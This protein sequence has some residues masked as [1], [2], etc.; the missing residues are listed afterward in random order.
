[1]TT[2]KDLQH[3]TVNPFQ[4]NT[5]AISYRIDETLEQGVH[6][7]DLITNGTY[8]LGLWLDNTYVG[9]FCGNS[10]TFELAND[11]YVED[12]IIKEYNE[13]GSIES[14]FIGIRHTAPVGTY[15]AQSYESFSLPNPI[16][17]VTMYWDDVSTFESGDDTGSTLE[18]DSPWGTQ[19]STDYVYNVLN[20]YEYVPIKVNGAYIDPAIE[21][22]DIVSIDG[23]DVLV[24]NV[25][26]LFDGITTA[27]IEVPINNE[28]NYDDPYN[29]L[30]QNQFK[31]KIS[32]GDAYQ[33]V[34]ISRDKGIE[35]LVSPDGT[36]ENATG[37]YY[38][39]LY[40]G[41]AFQTRDNKNQEWHDW[42]YFDLDEN[43]FKLSLYETKKITDGKFTSLTN[44]YNNLVMKVDGLSSEI[45]QIQG[46]NIISNFIGELGLF[47]WEF[48]A[49]PLYPRNDLYPNNKLHP[50]DRN[51]AIMRVVETDTAAGTGF[52]LFAVGK[53]ISQYAIVEGGSDYSLYTRTKGANG[54]RFILREYSSA[55][56][57]GS[58]QETVLENAISSS[59]WTTLNHTLTIKEH[60]QS[61][62][63]VVEK[64]NYNETT[65]T[66]S[67]FNFGN[68]RPYTQSI[69]DVN[70]KAEY[71]KA[72]SE[73]T[74]EGFAQ[75]VQ[76][77]ETLD[78]RVAS[79]ES[80]LTQNANE[81]ATKVSKNKVISEIN[82]SA[83]TVGIK[84]NKVELEG[85]TSINKHFKVLP[86]G[87]VEF[88]NATGNNMTITGNLT[89]G[90]IAGLNFN[91]NNITFPNGK[92]LLNSQ[93][94]AIQFKGSAGDNYLGVLEGAGL[95]GVGGMS[96][97]MDGGQTLG[98]YSGQY[99]TS[100]MNL[101]EIDNASNYGAPFSIDSHKIDLNGDVTIGRNLL[102]SGSSG[103]IT[104]WGNIGSSSNR[105]RRIYLQNQ[106]NVSSD[107]KFKK[108][109]ETISDDLIDVVKDIKPKQYHTVY[110]DK[111]HF[112]YIA[113]DV[114]KALYNHAVQV[115]GKEKA[116]TIVKDFALLSKD[117][118]YL[119]LLYGEIQVLKDAYYQREFK[120]LQNQINKLNKKEAL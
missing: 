52:E 67:S 45:A 77:V 106:P 20:G 53:A 74:A 101:H 86:N 97:R 28:I 102:S 108:M 57:T 65:F 16:S 7:I 17:K 9:M 109:I 105:W 90:R 2:F 98:I 95:G 36:E 113:Q 83:E 51:G 5:K 10:L 71:A 114:E 79:S 120:K 66:N 96:L 72:L 32:L 111:I 13:S 99:K 50:R 8:T 42:M 88:T 44:K 93:R 82:Q 31:R 81:I 94:N 92:L 91:N 54:V 56:G 80:K 73:Q 59:N 100:I 118:H 76:L 14:A 40:R 58:Y 49:D 29:K 4:L 23:H 3:G 22:G 46:G 33:G 75:T 84:A 11:V 26:W 63:M 37:R 103:G 1:M 115:Y 70:A 24:A 35:M 27:E 107:V 55:D 38:A 69:A 116:E 6:K 68:P 34:T 85:Y 43:M 87:D 117:E 104:S 39:D 110:D 78:D 62:R 41:I 48:E 64:T 19:E 12:V 15:P 89:A 21:L 112:G 61:V 47:D 30:I 60:T 25:R 18:I 119:S